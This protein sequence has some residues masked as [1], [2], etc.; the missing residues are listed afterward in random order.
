MGNCD[1]LPIVGELIK[2]V[3]HGFNSGGV[4]GGF[5]G[6]KNFLRDYFTSPVLGLASR[7]LTGAN[8]VTALLAGKRQHLTPSEIAAI[9][10]SIPYNNTIFLNRLLNGT[11]RNYLQQNDL[12]TNIPH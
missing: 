3:A 5:T 11:L 12:N 6:G 8:G 1:A 7:A 10:S 9:K 4:T 2:D